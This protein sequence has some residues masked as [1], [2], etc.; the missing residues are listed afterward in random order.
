MTDV[1]PATL[2]DVDLL[3]RIAA[4][5]FYD[6][7]VMTWL[8]PDDRARLGRLTFMFGGL[9]QDMLPDRGLVHLADDSAAAFW[10][11][12]SFEHG[13]SAADRVEDSGGADHPFTP[14]E[15][16]RLAIL[17]STMAANHPHEPHWYLNVVSTLPDHQGRGLGSS[18]LQS[19]LARCDE[20]GAR[21]YLESTNPR[22]HTLYHRHGFV[23]AGV[24]E[25]EGGPSLTK[26]WRDPRP[27]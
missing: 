25:L 19:V 1:R 24:I 17:G 27:A 3:A 10:R 13:R 15:L 9:A 11:D 14:D 26:M 8:V 16:E 18:L 4:A 12:P 6:D 22:N 7:P 5:G 23:D 2:E 20:D 21:A